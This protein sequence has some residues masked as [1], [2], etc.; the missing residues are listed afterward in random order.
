MAF[1]WEGR[2][3]C[4][5]FGERFGTEGTNNEALGDTLLL[6]TKK[7]RWYIIDLDVL[8]SGDIV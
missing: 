6:D 2:N 3:C 8:L 7:E 5:V 4:L 1:Q